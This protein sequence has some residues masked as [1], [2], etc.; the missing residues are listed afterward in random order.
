M[1]N[2][3]AEKL[4]YVYVNSKCMKR[5]REHQRDLA[6]AEAKGTSLFGL[7]KLH[8]DKSHQE[9]N[10]YGSLAHD[11]LISIGLDA[12]VANDHVHELHDEMEGLGVPGHEDGSARMQVVPSGF[13]DS[14]SSS[15]SSPAEESE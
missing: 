13:E 5:V 8:F 9:P 11:N 15:H 12:F 7:P 6:L 10:V 2:D 4:F 3:R 14:P 1:N